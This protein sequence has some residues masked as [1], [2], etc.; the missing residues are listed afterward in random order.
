[1][2]WTKICYEAFFLPFLFT[3]LL[4]WVYCIASCL[5]PAYRRH[6]H[7]IFIFI[8]KYGVGVGTVGRSRRKRKLRWLVLSLEKVLLAKFHSYLKLHIIPW[9]K[10]I[11]MSIDIYRYLPNSRYLGISTLKVPRYCSR[12][13]RTA[14]IDV[15]RVF[16]LRHLVYFDA[17]FDKYHR[18]YKSEWVSVTT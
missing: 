14:S 1:M 17:A 16:D 8:R 2:A 13:I 10:Y 11:H 9:M 12:S 4:D 18:C 7:K 3:F 6:A 15:P 5:L